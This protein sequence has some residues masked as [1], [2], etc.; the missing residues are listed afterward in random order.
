MANIES[1]PSA[2]TGPPFEISVMHLREL[3]DCRGP[4]A[5][6]KIVQQFGGVHNICSRLR[7]SANEGLR[8]DLTDLEHRR[9]T[10]GANVIPPKPPK[11]FFQ[12]VWEALQDVTLII[13]EVAALISLALAFYKPP[14]SDGEDN[15]LGAAG[16]NLHEEAEA[17]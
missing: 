13:L 1:G 3:M 12:L 7:T 16:G 4:E 6:Q 2:S 11:T 8:G 9:A 15:E 17:G 5:I 14:A 10:F